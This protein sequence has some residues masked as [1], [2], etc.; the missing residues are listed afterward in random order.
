MEQISTKGIKFI[1]TQEYMPSLLAKKCFL[2]C[3]SFLPLKKQYH[4]E[5]DGHISHRGR[6]NVCVLEL[7]FYAFVRLEYLEVSEFTF[8][9][10][11]V[12]YDFAFMPCEDSPIDSMDL[13]RNLGDRDIYKK[14]LSKWIEPDALNW[15]FLDI[16]GWRTLED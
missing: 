16:V 14:D 6:N 5:K 8:G 1:S 4:C 3:R 12:V 9:K 7:T 11:I 10:E 15:T 13:R 2:H